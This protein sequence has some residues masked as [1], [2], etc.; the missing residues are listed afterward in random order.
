VR[1]LDLDCGNLDEDRDTLCPLCHAL[2]DEDI[3]AQEPIA[4][5]SPALDDILAGGWTRARVYVIEG[6]SG[7]GKTTLALQ[8]LI[9][10]RDRGKGALYITFSEGA[11]ELHQVAA[12]RG[13]LLDSASSDLEL[14]ETVKLVM[15]EVERLRPK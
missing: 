15:A 5:G 6:R 8:F 10:A 13:W 4:S 12:R 11:D 7:S 9:A 2:A 1:H 14:G 3:I